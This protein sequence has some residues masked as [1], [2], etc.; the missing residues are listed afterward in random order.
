MLQIGL[1]RTE[2]FGALRWLK[3]RAELVQGLRW[4]LDCDQRDRG[5]KACSGSFSQLTRGESAGI[6]ANQGLQRAPRALPDCN[7]RA[8][9]CAG[10]GL[11]RPR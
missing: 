6:D 11:A 10:F 5:R 4:T 7:D 8:A 9:V 3:Q 1:H 2:Q